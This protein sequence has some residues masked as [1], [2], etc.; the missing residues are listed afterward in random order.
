VKNIKQQELHYVWFEKNKSKNK[1]KMNQFSTNLELG[2]MK[3][4]QSRN[5][6]KD[7]L[8]KN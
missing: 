4:W 6:T 5:Q 7:V 8:K 1:K 3:I 2:L